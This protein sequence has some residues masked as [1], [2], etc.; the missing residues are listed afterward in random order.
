MKQE[1]L[2]NP[3]EGKIGQK[4]KTEQTEIKLNNSVDLNPNYSNCVTFI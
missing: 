4:R 1:Y 2:I 3:K